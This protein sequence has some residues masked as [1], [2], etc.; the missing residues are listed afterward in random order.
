MRKHYWICLNRT[1]EVLFLVE[2]PLYQE[3]LM[4][5]NI[6]FLQCVTLWQQKNA[7]DKHQWLCSFNARSVKFY[8][9]V[10]TILIIKMKLKIPYLDS[11]R[12]LQEKATEAVLKQYSCLYVILLY[13]TD[14]FAT[15]IANVSR[16]LTT[17]EKISVSLPPYFVG[18]CGFKWKDIWRTV[19]KRLERLLFVVQ[20]S[21]IFLLCLLSMYTGQTSSCLVLLATCTSWCK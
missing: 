8:F 13:Q 2:V 15:T 19:I 5:R 10:Y 21:S 14:S 20:V 18:L 11:Y 17:Q 9:M 7:C 6:F 3:Q 1:R 12:Y 16:G 4:K